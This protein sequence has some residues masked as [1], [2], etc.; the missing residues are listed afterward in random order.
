MRGW[1]PQFRLLRMLRRGEIGSERAQ[2]VLELW[3][4]LKPRQGSAVRWRTPSISGV[5][6]PL[7][8]LL[9]FLELVDHDF[10]TRAAPS[11]TTN[12]STQVV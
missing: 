5:M 9:C 6:C 8:H 4:M 7:A 12:A 3:Y 1:A 11:A 10:E 2:V